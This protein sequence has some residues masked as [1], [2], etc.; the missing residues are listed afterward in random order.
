MESHDVCRSQARQDPD[1]SAVW[2]HDRFQEIVG[3]PYEL[4]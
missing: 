2:G 3:D 1:F 4:W